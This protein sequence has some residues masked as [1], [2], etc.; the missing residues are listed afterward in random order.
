MARK[1]WHCMISA[2]IQWFRTW[3]WIISLPPAKNSSSTCNFVCTL[4]FLSKK[5]CC[6]KILKKAKRFA[7]RIAAFRLFCGFRGSLDFAINAK[8][9]FFPLETRFSPWNS[10]FRPFYANH[11]KQI[12]NF[13]RTKLY[14]NFAWEWCQFLVTNCYW[15]GRKLQFLG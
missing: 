10:I 1:V 5:Q 2:Y 6:M 3:L 11:T 15:K 7:K 9:R 4:S 14:L 8:A 13:N 12:L